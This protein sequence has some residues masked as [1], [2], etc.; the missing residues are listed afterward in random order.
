MH[1]VG[2]GSKRNNRAAVRRLVSKELDVRLSPEEMEIYQ[3][4]KWHSRSD[5]IDES[6]QEEPSEASSSVAE[7][8][9][10]HEVVTIEAI[11]RGAAEGRE[12][13]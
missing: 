12:G 3:Q 9:I 6:I 5:P 11:K 10:Q 4:A 13:E 2:L 7:L 1:R 8:S